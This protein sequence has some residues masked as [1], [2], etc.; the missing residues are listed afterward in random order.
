MNSKL[1]EFSDKLK[2]ALEDSEVASKGKVVVQKSGSPFMLLTVL[3]ALGKLTIA[4]SMGWGVVFLPI[5]LPLAIGAA[6]I[7]AVLAVLF[8]IMLV[9]AAVSR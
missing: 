8:I 7:A 2:K 1:N 9:A 5:W 4:P 3:L 6:V